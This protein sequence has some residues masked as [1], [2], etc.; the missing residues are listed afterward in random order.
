MKTFFWN[1]LGWWNWLISHQNHPSIDDIL[2]YLDQYEAFTTFHGCR[3]IDLFSYYSSGL[4]VAD[5]NQ[6]ELIARNIFLN[7]SHIPSISEESFQMAIND[8]RPRDHGKLYTVLDKRCLIRHRG[9]YMIYG[10]E[11]LLAI[12]ANLTGQQRWD[13]F[14]YRQI[15]KHI[16]IPTII[17]TRLLR[18]LINP[19]EI[20][21]LAYQLHDSWRYNTTK[22]RPYIKDFTFILDQSIPP[23]CIVGHSNPEIIF[24]DLFFRSPYCYKIEASRK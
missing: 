23:E 16:G 1:S 6:L 5:E 12:G 10:S 2:N 15:L 21:E 4:R 18:S 8:T 22:K 11:F 14:D 19:S 17:Q 20:E 13:E 3:P 24:D 9:H 7:N